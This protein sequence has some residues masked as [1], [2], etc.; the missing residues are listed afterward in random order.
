MLN[1]PILDLFSRRD[2]DV[3]SDSLASNQSLV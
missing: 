1:T 3:N 2:S